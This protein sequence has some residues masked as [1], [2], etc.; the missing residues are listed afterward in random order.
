MRRMAGSHGGMYAATPAPPPDVMKV[1][2]PQP[3]GP[4]EVKVAEVAEAKA[5]IPRDEPAKAKAEAKAEEYTKAI[6][7]VAAAVPEAAKAPAAALKVRTVTGHVRDPQGRPLV[8]ISVGI[9]FDVAGLRPR[10]SEPRPP[11]DPDR[12]GLFIFPQPPPAAQGHTESFP[13]PSLEGS[14]S[15]RIA[16]RSNGPS[17]SSPTRTPGARPDR[18]VTSRSRPSSAI[19]SRS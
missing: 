19:A 2:G 6:G 12:D 1:A 17:R 5:V 11:S 7:P 13:L 10:T 15:W 18:R 9:A 8:G 16:T 14:G 4:D 3:I